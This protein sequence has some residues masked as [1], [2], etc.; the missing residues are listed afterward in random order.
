[1]EKVVTDELPIPQAAS[2]S[3]SFAYIEKRQP[4]WLA[5]A[6]CLCIY[7]IQREDESSIAHTS[8]RL[9]QLS[10]LSCFKAGLLSLSGVMKQ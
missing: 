8:A 9:K 2:A 5:L 4:V 6:T 3:L 7:F 10:F 1:L